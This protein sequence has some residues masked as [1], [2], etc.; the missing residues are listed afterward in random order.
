MNPI[1]LLK[2]A[3]RAGIRTSEFLVTILALILPVAL[4]V[5]DKLADLGIGALGAETFLGGLVAAI[6]VYVRGWLKV[7]A[8][9]QATTPSGNAVSAGLGSPA[10][11]AE[12]ARGHRP[13]A[14]R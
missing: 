6:Y 5:L 9:G 1:D 10:A 3:L 12:Y 8:A 7:R 2:K 13:F 14:E 4:A 11:E